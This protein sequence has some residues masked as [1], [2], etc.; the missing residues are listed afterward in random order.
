MAYRTRYLPELDGVRT[1]INNSSEEEARRNA[2]DLQTNLNVSR[3]IDASANSH[4][5]LQP[6]PLG[7]RLTLPAPQKG[8]QG[9]R[10]VINLEAPQGQLRVSVL[11]YQESDRGTP[12][13]NTV[14]GVAF[15]TFSATGIIAFT[16]NGDTRWD[17]TNELPA[18]SAQSR[19][20]AAG[21]AAGATGVKGDTGGQGVP[22]NDG[23]D[24]QDGSPGQPGPQGIPGQQGMPGG[25]G[26]AGD[27]GDQGFPGGVGATGATGVQGIPGQ[28]GAPGQDG[29]DGADGNPGQQGATG[30]TGVAGTN[31]QNGP[32][33]ENG[34]DGADAPIVQ[35]LPG[36]P[37][38]AGATGIPG[39]NGPPGERGDDGQDAPIVAGPV[40]PAGVSGILP[41]SSAT[42]AGAGPFNDYALPNL[43]TVD[44]LLVVSSAG[45]VFTGFASSGG[46]SDGERF[47]ILAGGAGSFQL[48]HLSG[49]SLAANTISCPLAEG[50]IGSARCVVELE[51]FSG[52]WRVLTGVANTVVGT[53]GVTTNTLDMFDSG[54]ANMSCSGSTANARISS[55]TS[56]T[57]FL[58]G[59]T[60]QANPTSVGGTFRSLKG[61]AVNGNASYSIPAGE[62]LI[63]SQGTTP[64]YLAMKDELA[65]EWGVG[66][67]ARGA[68]TTSAQSGAL[69]TGGLAIVS[70]SIVANELF[71]GS[72]FEFFAHVNV[73]RGATVTATSP[74]LGFRINAGV[75]SFGISGV[76]SVAASSHVMW[77]RGEFTVL[78]APG[79]AAACAVVGWS[80]QDLVTTG[81]FIETTMGGSLASPAVATNATVTLDLF[82]NASV[83]VAAVTRSVNHAYIRRIG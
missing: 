72:V 7:T 39:I 25:Q 19:A 18:E 24:G 20:I 21:G 66:Y 47:R 14:N 67:S 80:A 69:T 82:L 11:P 4:H 28:N 58:Q 51:Y 8:N 37:G 59:S 36:V 16:S 61:V 53:D 74:A 68:N 79:A 76:L 13:Q 31:G 42:E 27:Q 71:A 48:A 55:G 2:L 44:F 5:R 26:E 73:V 38:T 43:S 75:A 29:N 22:G 15:V 64:R 40:G 57:V 17:S 81:S 63:H 70:Q 50:F 32:P 10:V 35:G 1:E 78:A 3:R 34:Q 62:V 23:A 30:A 52:D 12:I 56:G 9:D 41:F 77:I 46:N 83:T 54:D 33:G 60:L 45:V 49:S 6:P 65:Q